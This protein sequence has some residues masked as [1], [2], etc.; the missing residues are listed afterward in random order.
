MKV[1]LAVTLAAAIPAVLAGGIT[2]CGGGTSVSSSAASA[3]IPL[4][5]VGLPITESS[6]DE[7]KNIGANWITGLGLETLLQFGPKRGHLLARFGRQRLLDL[8]ARQL[9]LE[10]ICLGL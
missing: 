3:T 4:L 10:P 7:T 6:L 1:R 5:R 8:V 9:Q 2:A